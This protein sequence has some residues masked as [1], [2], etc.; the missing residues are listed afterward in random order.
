M[1]PIVREYLPDPDQMVAGGLWKA[2]K[3]AR[4]EGETSVKD[5]RSGAG[6]HLAPEAL[7]GIALATLQ[8]VRMSSR[9]LGLSHPQAIIPLT[10]Q[11]TI[12]S[13]GG[14]A[15]IDSPICPSKEREPYRRN[16]LMR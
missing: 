7:G 11:R 4:G 9:Y 6:D 10:T 1:P 15:R 13:G 8:E 3:E 5:A 2:H 16:D 14:D 12:A